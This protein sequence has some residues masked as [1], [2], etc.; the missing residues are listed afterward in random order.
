MFKQPERIKKEYT[1]KGIT[2]PKWKWEHTQAFHNMASAIM[3]GMMKWW[4]TKEEKGR[5]YMITMA[6]LWRNK[7]VN[8]S[9][10]K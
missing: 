10:R 9:H 1:S 8:K 3:K 7:A 6:K 2:P 4:L 5:A